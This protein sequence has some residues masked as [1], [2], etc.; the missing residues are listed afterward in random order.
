M[1]RGSLSLLGNI[2]R[3][4]IPR[5]QRDVLVEYNGIF[6]LLGVK[7]G[8]IAIIGHNVIFP[9]RIVRLALKLRLAGI[10]EMEKFNLMTPSVQLP[11]A[12]SII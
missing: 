3:S 1:F 2:I 6:M 5:I 8:S 10:S 11:E 4:H 9:N 7:V 12:L